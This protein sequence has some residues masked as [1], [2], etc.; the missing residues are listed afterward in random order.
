[1]SPLLIVIIVCAIIVFVNR[2]QPLVVVPVVTGIVLFVIGIANMPPHQNPTDN[3]F[4][5]LGVVGMIVG[6]ILAFTLPKKQQ[7][8]SNDTSEEPKE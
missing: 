5:V 8:Q 1:M 2:K 6:A 3:T 4:F 7:H